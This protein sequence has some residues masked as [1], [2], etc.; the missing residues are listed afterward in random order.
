MILIFVLVC[1]PAV[2]PQDLQDQCPGGSCHPQ[3]GD[4][5]VGRGTQL[6]ASS[7]CGVDGPQN[8][9]IVGYLEGEKK[10]FTCDSRLPFSPQSNPQ[11]HRIENVVTTFDS[12]RRL[13]WWQSENGVH[14]VSIQLDLETVFQ[15]SHLVLTFKS[16]RP[17]AMLVERSKDFGRSWKVFRYFADD[18]SLHFPSVPAEPAS[19]I[20]DVVC[21]S[22][23]SGPEPSTGGEVVLKALDP[24]FEIDD[25][26]APNIQE[27]I[28]LTNIRVN[29]TRLFTLGDTLLARRRR[30][31]QE[32]YY[33]SLYSM[34][35]QGSCFCNGHAS[36]CVPV[37]GGRGDVFTQPGMVHGRCVCEH[38]TAGENCERCQPFHNDSPWKP[39]G[40]T[41]PNICRR[42]NCHG[43]SD[44][45]HF[46]A[47]RYEETG[48]ASGGVCDDCR[49]DRTGPQCE[50]CRPLMYQDPQRALEDPHAC[51]PCDCDPAGSH[52]GG[53]C[54]ASSGRCFC[55]ENVEGQRCDRCK[56]GF[57]DL[58]SDNPAGCEVCRCHGLGSVGPCDP[59]TGS[60]RCESMATGP[61]CDH[62][63]AGFWGLGNSVFKCSPC[64]CDVGGASSNM[65]SPE[66][67]QCSC[68]PNMVGR[69]C[70]D[71]APG[72]F[73]PSLIYFLYEAELAAQ[74]TG[75]T[76]SPSPPGPLP[77]FP[78]SSPL[79]N[80]GLLPPCEQYFRRQGYHFQLSNGKVI[81]I[82]RPRHLARRR[83]RQN[84]SPPNQGPL[85]ILPHQGSPEQ[86]GTGL[87]LVRVT[88]GAGL[89]FTVDNL[90]TSM[91][92]QLVIRYES[93]SDSDWVA[94]VNVITLSPGDGGCSDDPPTGS[95]TLILPRSSRLGILDSRV[96]LNA[97]GRYSVE[98][99]FDRQQRSDNAPLLVDSMGLV[100]SFYSV[101][102]DFC[103]Q[104]DFDS[105]SHSRCVG[106]DVYLGSQESLP[107]I[108]E[109]LI[110]SLSA[111]IH[112]GAVACRC[113]VIGS[114][115]S[116]CSM[117]GGSCE[118]KPSVI[119]R[120]CDTCAPLTFGFGPE[121]CKR[122]ECDSQGSLSEACDLSG[123]QCACRPRV[124]GRRCDRCESGF[125]GFPLCQPCECNGLSETCDGRTGECV[126]CREHSSGP[127]CDRCVEGYYGNPVSRQP[128]QP[129]LCPDILSSGR[130]FASSCRYN[131][132][133]VSVSCSC[134]EGHAG[135]RCDR[136][137][138]GFYGDLR[139]P[140]AACRACSCNNN[141]DPDDSDACDGTT[142]EC[143]RCLHYTTGPQCQF[144]KPGYYGNALQHN[145]K[146]C[147]CDRRG[148]KATLCPLE[149]PCFCD[150]R[151]GQCPCRT[152]VVGD[153]CDECEDGFWNL[154]GTS[155]CQPCSC[156]PANSV[157]NVCDKVSGQCP[158]RPEFGGRQCDKCGENHFGDPNLQCFSCDCNLEGTQRPSCDPETGECICRTGVSGILCDACAPGYSSE[159]PA[160]EKC[161]ECMVL[162]TE[163]ITDVQRAAQRMRTFIPLHGNTQHPTHSQYWQRMLEM[164][165][166]LDSVGNM[167]GFSLPKME[168]VEK[169]YMKI[170][171]LKDAVDTNI[172]LID[173]SVLLNNE[174]NNINVEFQKMLKNLKDKLTKDPN[175]KE[176]QPVE[177]MLQEIQK[178]H[179]TFMSDE[180]RVRNSIKAVEDSMDTRQET[181]RKLSMC[182]GRADLA[183]LEKKVKELNV[184]QLNQKICGR[185]DP[186]DCS[187]CPE[188]Q[189][190]D[191]A[192][193]DAQKASEM[194]EKVKEQLIKFPSNL[195]ESKKKISDVQQV[196]QDVKD[197]AQDLQRQLSATTESLEREKNQT[198]ELLQRV[199]QYLMDEMVPP[200]D[201]EKMANAVLRIQ[202]PRSP[203]EIQSMINEISNLLNGATKFQ[204]DLKKLQDEAKTAQE[205]LQKA[206]EAKEQTTNIDVKDILRDIIAADAAQSKAND[207]LEVANKDRDNA[208]DR[209]QEAGNKLNRI[210]DKLMN[211]PVGL[212]EEIE[213]LKNKTEKNREMA[214]EARETAES[215]LTNVSNDTEL[216]EVEEQF[217]LLKQKHLNKTLEDE[218]A[219]R[220]QEI[221]KE[222]EDMQR[223]MEDRLQQ[224]ED[225]EQKIQ[226]LIQ[227]KEEKIVEVVELL[228]TVESLQKEI[229]SKAEY[230]TT[231]SS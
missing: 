18:C 30:N 175:K 104:S 61:L 80:P 191:G 217:E 118:C 220:L 116:R 150:R 190:C 172:I 32:K 148:T 72:Y 122:C 211:Q 25:P 108:C 36:R 166:R 100:Q 213:A 88:E 50:R 93:E 47:A 136:C 195:D 58:R 229:A 137:S 48:G 7:T 53:L 99:F 85:Q 21:D 181:K 46:D 119:G 102:E 187:G 60:C 208:K 57:F 29:F 54:D 74:L 127:H 226:L 147:S 23:Y 176:T 126:D 19:F 3:L 33:Y 66:D 201:I 188:G 59:L 31:P 110:K 56:H 131:P 134:R 35:V 182:S 130:F 171:K 92:Y 11:S 143:L 38:S 129:C 37:D 112:N 180:K 84:T 44:S 15:F 45:C 141:I 209:I 109:G 218:A 159:F 79:V 114:L 225:L 228:Q 87:G 26:Y 121:G 106:L 111:R 189:I 113:N 140:G 183:T 62:C 16:F 170:R 67:G 161:H 133:S 192:V 90:P 139:L 204:E 168:K 39:G 17:A 169:L 4:L 76:S 75:G 223:Q 86:S 94:R 206:T 107:K 91:E 52:S 105:F 124:S 49:H 13:K 55:K 210:E 43:H 69:R 77:A 203:A 1:L 202:L 70:S 9:C 20:D 34:V 142:G 174:I 163:N 22:R 186:D 194:A 2:K 216:Q 177:E 42:C 212:L 173:P 149:S 14:Q 81:L 167:T 10:C 152:G 200:G 156:D 162:W 221:L 51:I 227:R 230:Y 160:C 155:G 97:R 197:Q 27:L 154:D 6:S 98:I 165:S 12:D 224:I 144:C 5:M 146:E 83:R 73:L 89:R 151:T 184:R 207:D 219:D 178:L 120:C 78:S 82:R 193:P 103:S 153:L 8:Y 185:P 215:A 41:T 164:H 231:C 101:Q 196:A 40:Q 63:V 117:L 132:Q 199:K 96:C 157:S 64:D 179:K 68:L 145:C 138:P 24:V 128:C 205:L 222:A 115:G 95:L 214:K 125:W 28:T 65:C 198:R 123:G 135:E 158:C 71:P